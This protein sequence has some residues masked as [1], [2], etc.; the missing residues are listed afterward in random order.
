MTARKRPKTNASGNIE[1]VNA[2]TRQREETTPEN[3]EKNKEVLEGRG[4]K[5]VDEADEE[6]LERVPV[7]T[8]PEV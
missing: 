7:P 3:W 1:I 5:T 8:Q 4:W 6:T 2:A